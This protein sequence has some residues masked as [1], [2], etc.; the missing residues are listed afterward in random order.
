VIL[1]NFRGEKKSEKM[2]NPAIGFYA[3]ERRMALRRT[4]LGQL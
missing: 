1:F 4:R 2:G 3:K